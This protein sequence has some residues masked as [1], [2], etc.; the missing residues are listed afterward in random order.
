ME[1]KDFFNFKN[2]MNIRKLEEIS[3]IQKDVLQA[4]GLNNFVASDQNINQT[5]I[6]ERNI[7]SF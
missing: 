3:N 6:F 4:L 5:A 7:R 1:M 2:Q